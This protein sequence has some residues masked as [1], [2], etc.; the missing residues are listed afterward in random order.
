MPRLCQAQ[1]SSRCRFLGDGVSS[2]L[3]SVQR[4]TIDVSESLLP[5]DRSPQIRQSCGGAGP[6]DAKRAGCK[7]QS[8][9]E[10]HE[11]AVCKEGHMGPLGV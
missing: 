5:L 8:A 4:N 1:G 10:Q 2:S 9:L 3:H 11:H 7:H 6:E